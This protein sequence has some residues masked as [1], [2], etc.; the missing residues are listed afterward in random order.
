MLR[1]VKKKAEDG[2][3][4]AKRTALS[5]LACKEN[6]ERELF[7]KLRDRGYAPEEATQAVEYVK[8]KKYLDEERYYIRL[9]EN[10]A[11]TKLFGKTRILQ[12]IRLKRFS[13]ETVAKCAEKA[14]AEIDF[15]EN[16][17]R[18]L[19]KI[20]RGDKRKAAMALMRRG[21]GQNEIKAALSQ[22]REE[23]FSDETEEI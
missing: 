2:V 23:P 20:Y 22:F 9:V 5:L 18:A 11:N 8:G 4:G 1:R 17:R 21:Y 16:C 13:A 3:E 12:E 19:A 15:E 10:A 6:T 7:E 14:F